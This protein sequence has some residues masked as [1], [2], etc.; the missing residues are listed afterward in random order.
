MRARRAFLVILVCLTFCVASSAALVAIWWRSDPAVHWRIVEDKLS[1]DF[2]R[3]D[4]VTS[5]DRAWIPFSVLQN[6]HRHYLKRSRMRL[7]MGFP[8]M[9]MGFHYYG[10]NYHVTVAVHLFE[11]YA[12]GISIYC[13][14]AQRGLEMEK[15]HRQRFPGLPIRLMVTRAQHAAADAA[16]RPSSFL[17]RLAGAP[18]HPRWARNAG[19][20]A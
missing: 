14:S 8:D 9:D 19:S 7:T 12:R 4:T 1:R 18:E 5:R 13:D 11:N 15:L 17:A 10:T 6:P 16:L 2:Q 20:T 3:N